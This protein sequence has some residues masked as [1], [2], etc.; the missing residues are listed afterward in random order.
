MM[1]P[2]YSLPHEVVEIG[3]T[4]QCTSES[5]LPSGSPATASG[6]ASSTVP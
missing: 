1:L 5:T 3:V 2:W 6:T 4:E